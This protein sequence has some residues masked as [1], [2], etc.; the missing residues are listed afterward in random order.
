MKKTLLLLCA[1][2]ALSSS[3]IYAYQNK[4]PLSSSQ[5]PPAYLIGEYHWGY[6]YMGE[7]LT[8]KADGTYTSGSHS[9]VIDKDDPTGEKRRDKSVYEWD[10]ERLK[11]IS[12]KTGTPK[13]VKTYYPVSWDTRLY[14]IKDGGYGGVYDFVKA[15]REGEEPCTPI[16]NNA[17]MVRGDNKDG[18]PRGLPKL[19]KAWMPLLKGVA[20][21][22]TDIPPGDEYTKR[23]AQAANKAAKSRDDKRAVKYANEIILRTPSDMEWWRDYRHDAHIILGVAALRKG[24][25]SAAKEHLVQAGMGTFKYQ[26]NSPYKELLGGLCA[27]GE[28]QAVLEYVN[29]Y[30][31]Y[32]GVPKKMKEWVQEVMTGRIPT[33]FEPE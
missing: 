19:P 3:V 18:V 12:T 5:K 1:L 21:V 29:A 26:S 6:W 25:V 20:P 14:L 31:H 17:F 10:G 24:N 7:R 9:D 30:G 13:T 2:C 22:D 28:R 4:K 11:I 27:K 16:G 32:S 33:L 15:I 8:L 23:L